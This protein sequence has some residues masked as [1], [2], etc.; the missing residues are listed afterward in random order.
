M[1]DTAASARRVLEASGYRVLVAND[2]TEAM[3]LVAQNLS[4]VA[5]VITD[6]MMI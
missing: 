4:E 6:I 5:L 2:G 3:A 1:T